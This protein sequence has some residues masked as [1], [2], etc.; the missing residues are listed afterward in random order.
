MQMANEASVT[1]GGNP[2]YSAD[3]INKTYTGED[4]IYIQRKLVKRDL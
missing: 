4:R 1:R 2:V 3:A